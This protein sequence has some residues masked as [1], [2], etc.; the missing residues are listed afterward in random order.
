MF[1]L[2]DIFVMAG[3][4][5]AVL[6][7]STITEDKRKFIHTEPFVIQICL[8]LFAFLVSIAFSVL[9]NVS[10][11]S[12]GLLYDFATYLTG[13]L[14]VYGTVVHFLVRPLNRGL[15]RRLITPWDK[16]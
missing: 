3:Y 16:G 4:I 2:I 12:G 6:L 9:T 15:Y 7:L 10:N 11:V 13:G 1:V 5:G 14:F 8:W